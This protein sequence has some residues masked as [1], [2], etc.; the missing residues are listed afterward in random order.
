[1]TDTDRIRF[2]VIKEI[3]LSKMNVRYAGP[4]LEISVTH[5]KFLFEVLDK[6]I[7]EQNKCHSS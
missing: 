6:S 7:K 2:E 5:L 3:Y 4:I 1:M